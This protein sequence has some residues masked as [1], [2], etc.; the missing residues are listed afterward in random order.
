LQLAP[1]T[2]L[3]STAAANPAADLRRSLPAAGFAVADHA[4]GSTPAVDF[5]PVVAAVVEVGDRPE[6]A[7]AQTRRWRIEL[8]DDLVPVLWV[9]PAASP[10]VAA[11]GLEAGADA[12]LARPVE[13]AVFVAQVRAMARARAATARLGVKAGESRLLGDQLRKAYAQLDRE[14]EM[15]R[16]VHRTF[17]PRTLPAVG[18]ARASVCYRPRSR[19]GGDFY[20]VRRLDEHH[21]GFFLGDVTGGATGSL[22]GVYV[23][24]AVC[25]KEITGSRYRL[26]PPEE[27]LVGVNRELIGLGLDDPP[28][29]A[30]LVGTVDARDGAVA[31]ARAGLPAPAFVPAAGEVQSWAVPGPFL[32]TADTGYQP[33]HGTLAPGDKLLLGSDG[34]RPDGDSIPGGPDRLL[35]AAGRHRGLTGQAFV[36]AVAR[37]LLPHVRH[38]DDFTLLAIEMGV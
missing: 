26:V 33:R 37:D 29:V 5:G 10:E 8:G 2:V 22:L 21:L 12:C 30:M 15:A 7:A 11:A 13:P 18:A 1:R 24:Q 35:E 32:G 19:A 25:F 28:L 17:L 20:D 23:K 38:P 36:D 9:L 3:L 16:R 14:L 4:L 6:V 34:T 31:I 27:V